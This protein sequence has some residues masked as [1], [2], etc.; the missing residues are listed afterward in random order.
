MLK[1][2][3]AL[4]DR[5]KKSVAVLIAGTLINL[6]LAMSKLYV[7]LRTNSVCITIDAFNSFFDILSC[8][9]AIVAFL[10]LLKAADGGNRF[11]Y[12]RAEYV[13]SFIVSVVVVVMGGV[14]LYESV[15][16][17]AMPTPI[18]F[19]IEHCVI[20]VVAVL[21]K[22]GMALF[23][24]FANKK[25]NSKAL[26]ALTLDSFLDLGI[27]SAS[28]IAFGISSKVNYAVDAIFGII[29][30]I[31]VAVFGLKMVAENFRSLMGNGA[32]EE[33]EEK[34]RQIVLNFP[35]IREITD[36]A[37]HDYG[38]M[39]GFGTVSVKFKDGVELKEAQAVCIRI[40]TEIKRLTNMD[41]IPALGADENPTAIEE[42]RIKID[43]SD[44]RIDNIDN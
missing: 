43:E 27:T 17:L 31:T 37:V 40:R 38:Y 28:L 36:L 4:K 9:V 32:D 20:I 26:K 39:R 18:W 34:I 8:G 21:V 30:S 3:H 23:Y 14:F 16:R 33:E 10:F 41:I 13:A 15:N 2:D 29:I 19:S 25:L 42:E 1:F 22:L 24:Y 11:G 44:K 6:G 12:G 5:V 7:G 35:E